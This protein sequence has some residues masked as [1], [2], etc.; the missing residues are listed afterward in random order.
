MDAN[1]LLK[2]VLSTDLSMN[3]W[4]VFSNIIKIVDM[5]S[6]EPR[7]ESIFANQSY[8]PVFKFL[9]VHFEGEKRCRYFDFPKSKN[10]IITNP[11]CLDC[12]TLFEFK[13][14]ENQLKLFMLFK[15]HKFNEPKSDLFSRNAIHKQFEEIMQCLA[16]FMWSD[17]LNKRL[18]L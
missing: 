1:Q 6:E 11:S 17:L 14:P 13:I 2:Q 9:V 16:A 7:L 5:S 3:E 8:L 12:A 18:T 15:E 4:T 10:L